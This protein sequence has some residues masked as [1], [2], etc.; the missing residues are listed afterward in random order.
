MRAADTFQQGSFERRGFLVLPQFH[1]P[2]GLAHNLALIGVPPALELG[3]HELL[4][5]PGQDDLH[6]ASMK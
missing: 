2:K 1:R 3:F 4:Q 5:F 6:I